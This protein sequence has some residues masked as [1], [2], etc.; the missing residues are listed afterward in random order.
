MKQ[1]PMKVVPITHSPI[2]EDEALMRAEF[3]A[4]VRKVREDIKALLDEEYLFSPNLAL[5]DVQRMNTHFSDA[6]VS[7]EAGCCYARPAVPKF[8]TES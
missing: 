7:M 8:G 5:E 4:K 2:D 1:K 6:V 3:I